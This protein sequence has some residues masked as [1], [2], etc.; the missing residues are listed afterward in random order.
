M[1]RLNGGV[2]LVAAA[3]GVEYHRQSDLALRK[4]KSPERRPGLLENPGAPLHELVGNQHDL[5]VLIQPVRG[6]PALRHPKF[7]ATIFPQHPQR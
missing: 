2:A 5:G 6:M 4:P 1:E 3:R 7:R